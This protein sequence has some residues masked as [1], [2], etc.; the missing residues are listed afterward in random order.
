MVGIELVEDENKTPATGL[1]AD[2]FETCKE[3]GLIIGKGGYFGNI[4]RIKPPMCITE[5]D[6]VFMLETLGEAFEKETN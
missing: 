3:L 1:T 5:E 4:L 6:I 2:A